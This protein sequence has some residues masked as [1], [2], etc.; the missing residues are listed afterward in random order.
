MLYTKTEKL[1][2]YK[3]TATAP[4]KPLFTSKPEMTSSNGS[5]ARQVRRASC[6]F[7]TKQKADFSLPQTRM[8][9][10]RFVSA[11]SRMGLNVVKLFYRYNQSL[12]PNYRD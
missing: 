11:S 5:I 1:K 10:Q 6:H 4:F 7:V 12:R 2:P 9:E 3:K 8:R